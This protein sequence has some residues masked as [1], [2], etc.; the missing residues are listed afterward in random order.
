MLPHACLPTS[1]AGW[2]LVLV[3]LVYI[4]WQHQ[5]SLEDKNNLGIILWI[6]GNYHAITCSVTTMEFESVYSSLP[7]AKAHASGLFS[8]KVRAWPAQYGR[9]SRP[10]GHALPDR[11]ASWARTSPSQFFLPH[12]L[13]L[14]SP[15]EPYCPPAGK[16][17]SNCPELSFSKDGV[18]VP[19]AM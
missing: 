12:Q 14:L 13:F 11:L 16:A 4:L 3:F 18:T 2:G 17:Q 9:A 19:C 5:T 6:H 1:L 8:V 10:C 15:P 7:C